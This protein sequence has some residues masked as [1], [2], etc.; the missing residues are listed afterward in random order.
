MSLSAA[1]LL[2]LLAVRANGLLGWKP[3]QLHNCHSSASPLEFLLHLQTLGSTINPVWDITEE[4][5]H[6]SE[7]PA[8]SREEGFS[9]ICSSSSLF[10]SEQSFT[11]E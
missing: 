4:I 1:L 2:F 7:T 5:Q 3:E 10:L 6:Q 9:H 8:T 11:Q